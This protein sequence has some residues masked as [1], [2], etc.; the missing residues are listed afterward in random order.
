MNDNTTQIIIALELV[1]GLV[2]LVWL[3]LFMG[4]EY[5]KFDH[6][7][8]LERKEVGLPEIKRTIYDEEEEP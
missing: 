5:K 3:L 1:V 7:R 6:K 8:D 4:L 2:S